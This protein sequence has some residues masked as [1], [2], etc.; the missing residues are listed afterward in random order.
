MIDKEDFHLL[1]LKYHL[2]NKYLRITSLPEVVNETSFKTKGG[3]NIPTIEL[4]RIPPG[5]AVT[6][7]G[8]TLASCRVLVIM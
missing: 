8:S 5:E 2:I 3:G 6:V 4:S 1:Y 7:G